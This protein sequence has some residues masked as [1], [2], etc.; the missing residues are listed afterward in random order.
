M[1]PSISAYLAS[2]GRKGGSRKG[3]SKRR[4]GAE[5]YRKLAQL[6]KEAKEAKKAPVDS[7]VISHISLSSQ[8]VEKRSPKVEQTIHVF[9]L[10]N[11]VMVHGKPAGSVI[12]GNTE[13][14]YGLLING[15]RYVC[16]APVHGFTIAELDE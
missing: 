5:H 12:D 7:R 2:I 16:D 4:G 9:L 14:G 15:H 11:Q 8:V 13:D 6:A 3:A 10:G 1:K